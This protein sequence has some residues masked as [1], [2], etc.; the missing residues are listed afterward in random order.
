MPS[1]PLKT[2][3]PAVGQISE[4]GEGVRVEIRETCRTGKTALMPPR[5]EQ[6]IEEAQALA[7]RMEAMAEGLKESWALTARF[8]DASPTTVVAMWRSGRNEK[9]KRLSKF[10]VQALGERYWELFKAPPPSMG[11]SGPAPTEPPPAPPADDNQ[12]LRM[13]DVERITSLGKTTIK[14]KM[15]DG[16]FPK[17]VKIS[18]RRM[19]WPAYTI[20][21]WL[22][23][24]VEGRA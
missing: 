9:G 5:K 7:E 10:E 17:P 20:K 2:A 3:L 15:A 18:T 11:Q 6:T 8:S 4:E 13:R 23:E 14:R 19:G 21:A 24:R 12:L 16:T 22:A 1:D